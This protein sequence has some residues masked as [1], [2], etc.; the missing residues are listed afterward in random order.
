MGGSVL[1]RLLIGAALLAGLFPAGFA[2]AQTAA[3]AQP[4]AE[5]TPPKP[6]DYS[7]P[8]SWLCRP[9]GKD[10]CAIDETATIVAADGK[11]TR[12]TWT[13]NPNAPIDRFYVYPTI[14][15][16]PTPNKHMI[17]GAA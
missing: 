6:N 11:L 12:E 2:S 13:A 15:T 1:T 3:T 16:D 5:T 9:G 8:K 10:A 17:A 14:S 7:D 4:P